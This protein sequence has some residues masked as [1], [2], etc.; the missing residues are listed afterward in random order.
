[1]KFQVELL[2]CLAYIDKKTN[3]PKTRLGYRCLEPKYRQNT[4]NMK[5]YSE[6]S[7]YL[8]S[9]NLFDKLTPDMFGLQ[10]E[11]EFKE[12]PNPTNPTKKILTLINIKVGNNVISVL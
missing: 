3:E 10:S 4:K 8:D 1:M 5:G 7:V 6:L 9:H 2:S 11:L 12:E